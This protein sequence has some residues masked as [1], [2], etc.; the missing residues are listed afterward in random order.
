MS[1]LILQDDGRF[2]QAMAIAAQPIYLAWGNG[3]PAWDA[4]LPTDP[5]RQTPSNATALVA[6]C[7][8]RL[9]TNV[10]FAQP[11]ANGLIELASGK[12]TEVAG[13]TPYVYLRFVFD[14]AD[15][16]NQTLRER[17][18]FVGGQTA[19]GLPAGQRYF[20]PGQVATLGRCYAMVRVAPFVR[21]PSVRMVYETVLPF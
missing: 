18:I 17:A 16:A 21:D 8:R 15:A 10:G 7:G 9:A 6:E 13:P 4:L 20:V 5:A 1:D 2:A 19:A 11:D 14:Y 12:Y 3:N